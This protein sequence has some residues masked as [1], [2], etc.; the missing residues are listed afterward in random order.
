MFLS[1]WTLHSWPLRNALMKI[2]VYRTSCFHLLGGQSFVMFFFWNCLPNPTQIWT[3]A[4]CHLSLLQ[5]SSVLCISTEIFALEIGSHDFCNTPSHLSSL[6]LVHEAS[7]LFNNSMS[8]DVTNPSNVFRTSNGHPSLPPGV[9]SLG[10]E[11]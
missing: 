6:S 3:W 5:P 7:F 1:N 10:T 11:S 9:L 2:I 4:S 8:L